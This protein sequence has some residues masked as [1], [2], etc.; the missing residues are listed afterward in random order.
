M[1]KMHMIRTPSKLFLARPCYLPRACNWKKKDASQLYYSIN[2]YMGMWTPGPI[3]L[4]VPPHYQNS[5]SRPS[6][7]LSRVTLRILSLLTPEC[8]NATQPI[9]LCLHTQT[10]TKVSTC[11]TAVPAAGLPSHIWRL[12][13][14]LPRTVAIFVGQSPIHRAVPKAVSYAH[15]VHGTTPCRW[16]S[17]VVPGSNGM[18]WCPG[19][20]I[21]RLGTPTRS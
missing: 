10:W 13:W 20:N 4:I 16:Q 19:L 11:T 3:P 18:M 15:H 1:G 14:D 6:S 17:T 2:T 8:G 12:G 5:P 21:L 9:S 7:L